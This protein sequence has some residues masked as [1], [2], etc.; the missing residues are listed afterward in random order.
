MKPLLIRFR[1]LFSFECCSGYSKGKTVIIKSE[2][3][4]SPPPPPPP[5]PSTLFIN[6][7]NW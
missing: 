7:P 1:E 5:P 3:I 2:N 6:T 4:I